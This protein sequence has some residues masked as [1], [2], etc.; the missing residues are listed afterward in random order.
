MQKMLGD[1]APALVT[2]VIIFIGINGNVAGDAAFVVLPPVAG[3]I[4]LSM[5]RHPLLGVFTAFASVAA[6]FCANVML[7]MS[8]SLAYGFT[9]AAA[10]LI[11]PSYQQTPAINYYFL[12][13]SCFLL[14]FVGTFVTE[15]SWRPGLPVWT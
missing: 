9:E 10:K 1:A 4:Y 11:D 14:S 13:V 5:G 12:V 3:V 8:D 6:G 7:G 15:K 2:W